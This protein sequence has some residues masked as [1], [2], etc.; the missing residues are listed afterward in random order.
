MKDEK[1]T[2]EWDSL[3]KP[4][5]TIVVYMGLLALSQICDQLIKHGAS[6]N[7][8][9]AVVE[10]GTTSS[11]K[12]VTGNLL[13]IVKKVKSEK[14]KSPS[15]IIVGNVVKLRRKLNWFN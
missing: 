4:N 9:I 1:L 15:L 3:V 7:L 14:L 6:K 8:P 10:Q 11:Q 13:N 2:L 5:Q 12:V